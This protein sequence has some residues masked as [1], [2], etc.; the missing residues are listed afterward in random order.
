MIVIDGSEGEGGGQILRSALS[1]SAITAQ[2]FELV[3]IRARRARPGLMRQHL[4]SVRAAAAI[5][6]AEL[7]GD[8][9]GSLRLRFIPGPITPG[10]YRFAVGTAGSAMLVLQTVLPPLLK[11]SGTSE[12]VIEGGTHNPSAPPFDFLERAYLP[13]LSRMGAVVDAR[14]ER[15]GFYPAGGGRARVKITPPEKLTPIE[16][17]ERGAILR[18]RI[19]S[20]VARLPE[21]IA[22]RQL[23]A[24]C[25]ILG[26]EASETEREV[27]DPKYGPGN[28]MFV[29]INSEHVTEIFSGFGERG[30]K[31]ESIAENAARDA[32]RYIAS[33]APIGEHLADQL[34]LPFALAGG[35]R[36]RTVMLS[37]HTTTQIETVRRFIDMKLD[38]KRV[39]HDLV[40][41][42]VSA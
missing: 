41:L 37:T 3:N 14:L 7:E 1:L 27:L 19:V 22:D 25:A 36:F 13:I 2:P 24:A 4:T 28:V 40:E 38:E 11:S 39:G 30:I 26:W 21:S 9:I 20:R 18:R 8:E 31:A 34:L 5:C 15:P 29:E 12:V 35:G 42:T 23:R 32:H 16:L 10:D 6:K 33:G 17:L